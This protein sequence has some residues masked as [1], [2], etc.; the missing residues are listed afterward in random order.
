MKGFKD[1]SIRSK[2]IFIQSATAFIAVLLCCAFFVFEEIKTFKASA[3]R[4]M[5]SVARIAGDNSVS[6]LLF[7]DA[8]AA[9]AILQSLS[10]EPD[11]VDAVLLDKTGKVFARYT[12]EGTPFIPLPEF[13]TTDTLSS[14]FSKEKLIVSYKIFQ[15]T[16]L[17]GNVIIRVEMSDL[18]KI[19]A[20]YIR[21]AVLVLLASI[22]AAMLISGFLQR[23]ITGRLLSLVSKTKEVADTGSYTSRVPVEARD[24]IGVLSEE[25]NMMLERIEKME[26]SLVEANVALDKRVKERTK[27]LE[28]VNSQLE[29]NVR[30][31]AEREEQVNLIIR[32]APDPVVVI[33]DKG[34]ITRWNTEAEKTFGWKADEVVGKYLHEIIIPERYREAHTMG[35]ARF[36]Q[37]GEGRVLNKRIELPALRKD[38]TEAEM[39]LTISP[40]KVKDEYVFIAFLRDI[41]ERKKMEAEL[42]R[43]N[44]FLDTVL[45]N[46]PNM[47]FVKDAKELRFVLFNKAGEKLL[48]YNR[49][50][51]IGRNDYDFFPEEQADFFTRKDRS[52]LNKKALHD[53]PEEPIDTRYGR[54]W[55]HTQKVPVVDEKGEPVYLLGISEDIT[56]RKETEERIRQLNQELEQKIAQL[57]TVNKELDAFS[58][59]ISHDLRAPLRAI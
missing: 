40:T 56:E 29:S 58:Y 37:T 7:M 31:L 22:L 41:T 55:L 50:D 4:K 5:Y 24:E 23:T 9:T 35:L 17:L 43:T 59:S 42:K 46:I 57:E 45:E 44:A 33:N 30:Q 28:T 14:I 16:E 54:R 26:N 36:R 10:K 19:I 34:I 1:I 39:E 11:I 52:V 6:P 2:L 51:L 15:E 53:I 27:E 18:N 13:G 12:R 48:G 21:A 32:N 25:F 20:S 38:G 3:V 8:D 47:I 49:K